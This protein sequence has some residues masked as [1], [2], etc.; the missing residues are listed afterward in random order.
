ML[1][2]R[3]GIVAGDVPAVMV[4]KIREYCATALPGRTPAHVADQAL[5][6]WAGIA[7]SKGMEDSQM[8]AEF[9]ANYGDGAL[10]AIGRRSQRLE[11]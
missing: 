6:M 7:T 1:A 11:V 4:G 2:D 3:V 8:E 5:M 10:A 9:T